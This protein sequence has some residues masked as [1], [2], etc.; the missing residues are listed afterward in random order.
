M[1]DE[2]EYKTLN[3]V[4]TAFR[5]WESEG[6]SSDFAFAV[7]ETAKKCVRA[8]SDND[9]NSQYT[10][11]AL[12][13]AV[14]SELRNTGGLRLCLT[15]QLRKLVIRYHARGLSTSDAIN[16]ILLDDD[17]MSVTPF[18]VLKYPEVCGYENIK[19]FL[20][21]RLSYLKP[22]HPRFPKKFANYWRSERESYVDRIQDIPLSQPVEQLSKLSEHYTDLEMAYESAPSAVDKERFHKCMV[23]TMAAIHLITRDPS[24]NA[25]NARRA[26]SE[27][28]P[29]ALQTPKEEVIDIPAENTA[30]VKT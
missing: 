9:Y 2:V 24:I 6:K 15:E 30:V 12:A 14:F 16:E 25:P 1:S 7:W 20:V 23:R 8:K 26:I 13:Y 11:K 21:Q 19:N 4:Y 3:D 5:G 22:S 17:M 28:P 27:S 18:W 29:A 10:E